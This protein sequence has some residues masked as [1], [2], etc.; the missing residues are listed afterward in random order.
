MLNRAFG[1]IQAFLNASVFGLCALVNLLGGG[2]TR[3]FVLCVAI[4]ALFVVSGLL[5][6]RSRFV[7]LVGTWAVAIAAFMWSTWN[8]SWGLFEGGLVLFAILFY[9][10]AGLLGAVVMDIINSANTSAKGAN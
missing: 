9:L 7:P 3:G 10:F 4:G 8:E 1:Q 2:V 6:I 5:T